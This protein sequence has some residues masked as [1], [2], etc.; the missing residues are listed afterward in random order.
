VRLAARDQRNARFAA[1]FDLTFGLF[2]RVNL[3]RA[4]AA[5]A[6]QCRQRLERRACSAKMVEQRAKGAWAD[7]LTANEAEPIEALLIRQTY[8]FYAL[9]HPECSVPLPYYRQDGTELI[10]C[11]TGYKPSQ[12]ARRRDDNR[13]G[14][15]CALARRSGLFAS[16]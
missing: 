2:A 8:W 5:A 9:A 3:R 13:A 14:V 11:K 15:S 1:S 10:C 6:R 12:S 7:I 4:G 16:S